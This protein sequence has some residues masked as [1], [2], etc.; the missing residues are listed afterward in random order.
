MFMQLRRKSPWDI[1][2]PNMLW[3]AACS[4]IW[5]KSVNTA[6]CTIVAPLANERAL[7]RLL[8]LHLKCTALSPVLR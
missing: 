3:L 1:P 2:R 7:R 5:G 4:I 8:G 6:K